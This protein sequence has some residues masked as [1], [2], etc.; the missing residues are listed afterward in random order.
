MFLT[1]LY[2][3]NT[4]GERNLT[5]N[6]TGRFMFYTPLTVDVIIAGHDRRHSGGKPELPAS[7]R[8]K[9][10]LPF[11]LIAQL[12]SAWLLNPVSGLL[13]FTCTTLEMVPVAVVA[14]KPWTTHR[15]VF[16]IW[17]YSRETLGRLQGHLRSTKHGVK[18]CLK[19]KD[20]LVGS[21]QR[22]NS[23]QAAG[24]SEKETSW[25][26]ANPYLNLRETLWQ[27]KEMTL[28]PQRT[29]QQWAKIP[30]QWC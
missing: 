19:T 5:A 23:C 29:E 16:Q 15:S 12:C 3:K 21:L 9:R 24:M 1:D 26:V 30:P 27:H 11:Q 14:E 2:L 17:S 10:L 25:C 13:F 8:R 28:K 20:N 6:L 22:K 18:T 4:A 7:E